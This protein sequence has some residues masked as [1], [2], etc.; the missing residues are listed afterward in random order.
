M[1]T[2]ASKC[3]K[4]GQE[5]EFVTRVANRDDTPVCCGEKTTR[6]LATPMIAATLFTGHQ[7]FLMEDGKNGGKGTW[8]ETSQ[9]YHRYLKENRKIPASEGK[10]EAEIKA[11]QRKKEEDRKLT[12]AVE[13]AV[14]SHPKL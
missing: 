5:H 8:I 12:A 1:P 4:C 13:K 6:V 14:L 3:Q 7:A 9:D 10:R 2:Y 11:D